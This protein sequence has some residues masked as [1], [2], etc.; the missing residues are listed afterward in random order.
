MPIMIFLDPHK[1]GASHEDVGEGNR[2]VSL[3]Q[4][5]T[6]DALAIGGIASTRDQHAADQKSPIRFIGFLKDPE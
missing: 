5:E 2:V 6:A 4:D 1:A 3:V